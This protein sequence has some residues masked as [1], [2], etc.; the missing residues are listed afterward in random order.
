LAAVNKLATNRVD[1][2]YF[3]LQIVA[4]AIVTEV[5]RQFLAINIASASPLNLCRN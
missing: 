5:L 2:G 1:H 3:Q 4:Q